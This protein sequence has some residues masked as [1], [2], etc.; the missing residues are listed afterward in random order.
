MI[1]NANLP[2]INS[3][4]RM[5][6]NEKNVSSSLAKLS[7]GLRISNNPLTTITNDASNTAAS[8]G[9]LD[10]QLNVGPAYIVELSKKLQAPAL[11][12]LLGQ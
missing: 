7:N 12:G 10:T 4:N 9:S 2:A 8:K 6:I 1:I 11:S 3:Y 5:T